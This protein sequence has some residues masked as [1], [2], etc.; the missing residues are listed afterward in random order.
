MIDL[1]PI[2]KRIQ[3]RLFQKM[4]LLGREG[5]SPNETVNV[6]GLTHSQL[7]NR[8][9]FIRMTSGLD[10]PVI[11]MGGELTSDST[12]S[13]GNM[14]LL[15]NTGRL[16]AGYD[17]I[18]G[19]R[20]YYDPDDFFQENDLGKN[21][22]KRPMPG[23]KSIDVQ[24]RGGV[25][26][27]REGTISWTCW[28]FD[29]INRLSPHF[30]SHGTTVM[31]E[32]GWVYGKDGLKNL[33]TL[34]DSKNKIKRDTFT[35]Y[36]E[37]VQ[38]GNGDF[39]FMLGIVKN[40]E[41]TTRDDGAF[42]CQTIITSVGASVINS[43]T[44]S[45][46]SKNTTVNLNIRK[47]QTEKELKEELQKIQDDSS[48][49]SYDTGVTLKS[50][51]ANIHNYISQ[52]LY[53]NPDKV[54][55]RE[56]KPG[57][58]SETY[59]DQTRNKS[60]NTSTLKD[61]G[62]FFIRPN[63]YIYDLNQ[64]YNN[65][66]DVWVTW[67]WFED[68]ILSKFLTLASDSD[69]N[70]F[71]TQFRSVEYVKDDD[72]KNI[73]EIT[74]ELKRAILLDIPKK[75]E[76][77]RIR[78]HK[79]LRTVNINRYILPGK[80]EPF[81]VKG[82]SEKVTGDTDR[83]MK[84]SLIVNNSDNFRPFDD[85]DTG[86]LRNMLIN[87]ETIQEAFQAKNNND[88]TIETINISEAL[89][90]LFTLLNQDINFW[91]FQI[92]QDQTETTRSK[93]IDTQVTAITFDN[94]IKIN[95]TTEN[96]KGTKSVYNNVAD[97][98]KNNGVFFFP[99]WEKDSMVTRQ[100]ITAKIPDAMA[101]SIMY[102]ANYDDIKTA[103]TLPPEASSQEASALAGIYKDYV[104]KNSDQSLE[105][106]DIALRKEGFNKIG[107]DEK[108]ESSFL[109]KDGSNDDVIR[110]LMKKGIGGS[111]IADKMNTKYQERIDTINKQMYEAT[112][113]EEE[114]KINAII[115]DPSITY[116]LPMDLL[117]AY[118]KQFQTLIDAES[119]TFRTLYNSV[120]HDN[121]QMKS[122]F[123]N[124]INSAVSVVSQDNR[125]SANNT[126]PIII[127]L[128]VELDIDGIGGIIPGN[129]F[130]STYLPKRYQE[131][132]VFQLFDVNH[133]V[134]STGWK[135]TLIGKMRSTF[136]K[137]TQTDVKKELKSNI[138]KLLAKA[139]AEDSVIDKEKAIKQ[140][141]LASAMVITG[142]N[143]VAAK[144]LRFFA[145]LNPWK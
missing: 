134:D 129:S 97:E 80:L 43:I 41:Y 120:F 54:N 16:A 116:P 64:V 13:E 142:G 72:N 70:P 113:L 21:K 17:E 46:S 100:N 88:Y 85:G 78:T 92:T 69:T 124:T 33:P 27:L 30:L 90:S 91:D 81:K 14:T 42:D 7:A 144:V 10:T 58:L 122:L 25:R 127:P 110:Y 145:N 143:V 106:I 57:Y 38:E 130:H 28:S 111:S 119:D 8:T 123:L 93:I 75:L 60:T 50:F 26:A 34:V 67:G 20:S 109:S 45:N 95:N 74:E 71:V 107:A 19:P 62:T 11:L 87:I 108:N 63:A 23:I 98:V 138:E 59:G 31:L 79:K 4:K 22:F 5:N 29:D 82:D 9:P 32:W 2:D 115:E 94:D 68:N 136:N 3:K 56:L 86:F 99:V 49:L 24:F 36:E 61:K 55:N 40:F 66:K 105:N 128:E 102:G 131:E 139:A 135:V 132:A 1:T 137:M 15:G 35:N 18:Y 126:K 118:P 51:I 89:E 114:K 84:L 104:N 53:K 65:V 140:A 141:E 133:N 6:G 117:S 39:D 37:T 121:G 44:P 125:V 103:N 12:D 73:L 47:N 96:S 77:V 52:D 48:L 76:S 112:V 101:L 83:M